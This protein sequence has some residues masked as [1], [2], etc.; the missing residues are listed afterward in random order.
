MDHTSSYNGR[1]FEGGG[2]RSWLHNSRFEWFRRVA[3]K[4]FPE[5]VKAIELGCFD[6]R[7][8]S[9]FPC[10]PIEYQGF[11][12][13]WEG[14]LEAAQEKFSGNPAWRFNKA[15]EPR[16]LSH[17]PESAFKVAVALETLEHVPP[18]DAGR[19][20][21]EL[22][23]VTNGYLAVSVPNEKGAVFL[24]KYFA[25]KSLHGTSEGYRPSEVFN[26]A[27]G[28]MGK[29]GRHEHK[30]FDYRWMKSLI[31]RHF[32]LLEMGGLPFASL[33]PALSFSV[34]FVARSRK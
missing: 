26:A 28:R 33:P 17:L 15:T 32:D 18:G 14:G 29:V 6:G 10:P 30:G 3:F 23:R 16:D 5:P 19:Y 31:S 9:Y 13:G 4:Y 25:K 34:T 8:L 11:D 20:L 7:L 22:A 27:L 1:L 2:L 24:A 21:A 12:A